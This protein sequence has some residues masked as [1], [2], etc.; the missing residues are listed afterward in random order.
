MSIFVCI[1]TQVDRQV[2]AGA[3]STVLVRS[4]GFGAAVG[5]NQYGQCTPPELAPAEYITMMF[6]PQA[7]VIGNQ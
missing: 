4:D 7:F 3:F 2:D 6:E 1:Y 5:G